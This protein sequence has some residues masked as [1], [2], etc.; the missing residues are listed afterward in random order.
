MHLNN[1]CYSAERRLWPLRRKLKLALS[2]VKLNAYLTLVSPILEYASVVC[3]TDLHGTKLTVSSGL[4]EEQQ[5]L[6]CQGIEEQG[7]LVKC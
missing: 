2:E 1:L 6:F 7:L 5:G 3:G 4:E